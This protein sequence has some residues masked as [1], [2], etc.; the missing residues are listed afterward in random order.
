MINLSIIKRNKLIHR[1]KLTPRAQPGQFHAP[2]ALDLDAITSI[3]QLDERMLR[4]HNPAA[5]KDTLKIILWHKFYLHTTTYSALVVY[6]RY[7]VLHS[8]IDQVDIQYFKVTGTF[9]DNF[10]EIADY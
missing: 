2:T 4:R 7:N 3:L 5:R 10:M 8:L 9:S 1:R 6:N